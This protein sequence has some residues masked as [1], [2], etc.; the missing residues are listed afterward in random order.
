MTDNAKPD[1]LDRLMKFTPGSKEWQAEFD[2]LRL[3]HGAETLPEILADHPEYKDAGAAMHQELIAGYLDGRQAMAH[4]R[5]EH[6]MPGMPAPITDE[7]YKPPTTT[8][9]PFEPRSEGWRIGWRWAMNK[10]HVRP[11]KEAQ[12]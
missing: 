11:D 12:S 8:P 1:A 5:R 9:E 6:N 7:P 2:Q 4:W 3:E 10:H